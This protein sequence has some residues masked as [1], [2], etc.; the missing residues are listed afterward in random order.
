M[1]K[2]TTFTGDFETT[3]IEPVSVWLA[4]LCEIGNVSNTLTLDS[5]D[6]F[7]A[8][9]TMYDN[10]KV[11]F[12][13]LAFDGKFILNWLFRK[14]LMWVSERKLGTNTFNTLITDDGKFY[15]IKCNLN[16]CIITFTDSYKLLPF[17]V[18]E[19]AESFHLP[20]KKGEID[21][22]RHNV[23]CKI[24]Q[25]E[26]E[27]QINDV[28]IMSMALSQI[29]EFGIQ[30]MTIGSNALNEYIGLVGKKHFRDLFP[31][32]S[33]EIDSY[34]RLAYHGGY[35]FCLEK[36]REIQRG[37]VFDVNSLYPYEMYSQKYPI[38][39]PLYYK[40][41]YQNNPLYDLYFQH[42]TCYF[43]L[44]KNHIPIIQIKKDAR[45]NSEEYLTS[46]KGCYV[47]LV[48]TSV[49]LKLFL[50]HYDVT[51][52][53][54]IDGYMFKSKYG[55]FNEYIDKWSN[56]KIQAKK[57]KQYAL[58]ILSKLMLNN[59][60]GKFSTN[61]ITGQKMP[62]Y[63]NGKVLY[64]NLPKEEREPIYIPVGAY[65]TSYAREKTVRASQQIHAESINKTGKTR[66]CYSDTDS[67][68]ISGVE[69]PS[70]L[71]VDSYK[72]G[73]WDLETKFYKARFLR[74]KRYIEYPI[75]NNYDSIVNNFEI[76][77]HSTKYSLN[78]LTSPKKRYII[79]ADDNTKILPKI[80]CCGMPK[81]CY[82][83]VNWLN[84]KKGS[85]FKG[86][87]RPKNVEG[88]VFLEECEF[89]MRL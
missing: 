73:A 48:L 38:G 82:E 47:D 30:K 79:I 55:L 15:S 16:G 5:I 3:S 62:V 10:V 14:K 76:K 53:Q 63:V 78:G 40:G 43:E 64:E 66:Y 23:S 22:K 27:Y 26:R 75:I 45:F 12:H 58:Y 88:G 51:C 20:I 89:T 9:L 29:Y 11:I 85:I 52:L 44:K 39:E 41:E 54:Y 31:I 1:K 6:D 56:F 18:H 84:Y 36:G 21:Y 28:Q 60:Y 77:R 65:I 61:P 2:I 69:I 83:Q 59:L 34:I 13:N 25:E 32:L 24:T 17:S 37:L 80:T 74:A 19:I 87:L 49:D 70:F 71:E 67:I 50:E 33:N 35:T 86:K 8:Y 42:V 72:L 57:Q 81:Q 4:G 46:S 7:F 68:H